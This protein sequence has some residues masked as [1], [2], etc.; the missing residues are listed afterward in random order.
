MINKREI[1]LE[2]NDTDVLF[3][4]DLSTHNAFVNSMNGIN[5]VQP[6][7]NFVM[8]CCADKDK[9]FVR[10]L[11]K[12]DAGGLIAVQI[13]DAI[14]AAYMPEINIAVKKPLIMPTALAVTE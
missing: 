6:S 12:G 4:V 7:H 10:E 11:L 3:A 8:D 13:A 1:T 5:K 14:N 2:I 9:T